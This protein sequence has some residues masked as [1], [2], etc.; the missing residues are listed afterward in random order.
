MRWPLL[1][2]S[3]TAQGLIAN[4]QRCINLYPENNPSD[5]PVPVT[6]YHT[7]GLETFIA[8]LGQGRGMFVASDNTWYGVSGGS[9]WWVNAAGV[10][11]ILGTIPALFTPVRFVDNGLSLLILD[12]TTTG[13]WEIVLATKVFSLFTDPT[14]LFQGATLG[15]YLD[16]FTIFNVPGTRQFISTLSNTL[17][18][19]ATYIASKTAHPDL[20][21]APVVVHRELWLIGEKTSEI[22][23]TVVDQD[24]PFAILPGAFVQYGCPAPYSIATADI[25]VF[26]LSQNDQGGGMVLRGKG[27][28]TVRISTHALEQEIQKYPTLTDAIGYTY[29]EHGHIFYVLTFPTADK[30]W[31]FDEA[32]Q[33]WH[34]RAWMDI[35]GKLHRH[36]VC[37]AVWSNG[38]LY[39]QDWESGTVY[40][41]NSSISLDAGQ[42]ILRL[43]SFPH[44]PTIKTQRGEKGLEGK[45]IRYDKFMADISVGQMPL[46]STPPVDL[47]KL[48]A[49]EVNIDLILGQGPLDDTFAIL[50]EAAAAVTP[51]PILLLRWSNTRGVSW[52]GSLMQ[53]MGAAGEYLTAP[54]WWRL[55][56]ARDRVW[57]LSWTAPCNVALNGAWVELRELVS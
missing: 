37:S 35:E 25:S 3:Y 49:Q 10:Q 40:K 21:A 17:E 19:D 41:M 4:A 34:E 44:L 43:R 47:N 8:G 28:S 27:Y 33:M 52:Q 20:L 22:W 9:V 46:T 24:F 23:T 32:T 57:E 12:G 42:P 13:A 6:H 14:G 2:G 55:G 30:T 51:A 45:R 53:T 16:T 18:F 11:T 38:A 31:V 56:I 39:G 15:A 36:R 54:S 48:L 29:Q 26:F 50:L 7:P 1:G 5:A